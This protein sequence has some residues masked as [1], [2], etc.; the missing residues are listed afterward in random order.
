MKRVFLGGIIAVSCFFSAAQAVD[1]SKIT[2]I[3]QAIESVDK[4]SA[5]ANEYC[6]TLQD[7]A[8]DWLKNH[9]APIAKVSETI[10]SSLLNSKIFYEYQVRLIDKSIELR[11]NIFSVHETDKEYLD[12][13]SEQ[14]AAELHMIDCELS[15]CFVQLKED[16]LGSQDSAHLAE[17]SVDLPF[18]FGEVIPFVAALRI[19][20]EIL[21]QRLEE[22]KI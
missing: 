9:Y 2:F 10:L 3:E 5:Y 18:L 19:Q 7:E 15:R 11:T 17:K 13:L 14:L 12:Q 4:N 20:K 21:L 8:K 1:Q 6:Q 22:A 16:I